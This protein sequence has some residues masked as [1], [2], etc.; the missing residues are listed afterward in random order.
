MHCADNTNFLNKYRRVII[1]DE[2]CNLEIFLFIE[3]M[4]KRM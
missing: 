3:I 4:I 1:K 2:I